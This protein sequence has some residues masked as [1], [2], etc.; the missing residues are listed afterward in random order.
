MCIRDSIMYKAS[1]RKWCIMFNGGM[2]RMFTTKNIL[3]NPLVTEAFKTK[4]YED[5]RFTLDVC[6]FFPNIDV[7]KRQ[8]FSG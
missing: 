4:I 2:S 6:T 8:V 7:Y 3:V 5:R 1:I